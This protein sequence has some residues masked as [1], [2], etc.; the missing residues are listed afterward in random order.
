VELSPSL[1]AHLLTPRK[2]ASLDAVHPSFWVGGDLIPLLVSVETPRL[3]ILLQ[4]GATQ[5]KS[6]APVIRR[7]SR[8]D[9][10]ALDDV[11]PFVA[12]ET[13]TPRCGDSIP[14]TSWGSNLHHLL[15]PNQWQDFR[16]QTF[17]RTAGHCEICGFWNGLECHE[18][19]EY[20]EP[21][22]GLPDTICG[23]QRLVRLMPLCTICHETYHLGFAGMNGRMQAAGDRV[24]AYNR[25]TPTETKEYCDLNKRNWQRRSQYPWALDLSCVSPGPL[26]IRKT[27]RRNDDGSISAKTQTGPS[28]TII[29]GVA[30]QCGKEAYS[31]V[32]AERVSRA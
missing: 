1:P 32:P 21:I 30:W 9:F 13:I 11:L 14:S 22:P 5:S 10:R 12:K 18:L 25:F 29:L 31:A 8:I 17:A 15:V 19:W 26:A 3:P 7:G 4:S 16:R 24:M 23:V 27:W 2:I 28:V 20:H 6:G